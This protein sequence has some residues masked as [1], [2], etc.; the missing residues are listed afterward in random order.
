MSWITTG[1]EVRIYLTDDIYEI[2]WVSGV[3]DHLIIVDFLDWKEQ[4]PD[5]AFRIRDLYYEQC[6]VLVPTQGGTIVVDFRLAR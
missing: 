6:E 1:Q 3:T 5:I 4:W 2:G